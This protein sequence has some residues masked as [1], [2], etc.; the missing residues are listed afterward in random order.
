[1]TQ[2]EI[3]HMNVILEDIRHKLEVVAEGHKMLDQKFDRKI[4][5][6]WQDLK[7][8]KTDIMYIKSD[9]CDIKKDVNKMQGTLKE[10]HNLFS[11]LLELM[12]DHD[13]W[14]RDH[15]VQLKTI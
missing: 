15:D 2:D 13:R 10:H 4:D 6:L 7:I 8:V 1:M 12:D 5:A 14:L 11:K 9:I 3:R